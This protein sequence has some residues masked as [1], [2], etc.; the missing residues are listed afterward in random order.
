MIYEIRNKHYAI[1]RL[2]VAGLALMIYVMVHRLEMWA[3]G[4][5]P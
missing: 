5:P 4:H 3:V 1:I 2:S